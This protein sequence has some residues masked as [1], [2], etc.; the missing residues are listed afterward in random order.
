MAILDQQ[1]RDTQAL[2]LGVI[3]VDDQAMRLREQ[4]I[5]ENRG[6]GAFE[7]TCDSDYKRLVEKTYENTTK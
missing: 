6:Y 5:G 7:A 2:V 4:A 3:P 1:A